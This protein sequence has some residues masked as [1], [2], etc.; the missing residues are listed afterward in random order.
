M[1]YIEPNTEVK[2]LTDVPL[3]PDY[4][5]T[6]YFDN[7][8][9]QTNYF[10][11]RV[12][13]SFND[14]S[15][16]R[17]TRGWL[18]VGW[19]ADAFGG[20]VIKDMYAS[21]YMMFKNSNFENKW[22]YAFVDKVEYVNNNTVDVQYHIDVMQTWHFDYILNQCFIE[23]QH[24]TTDNI[25]DNTIPEQLETGEYLDAVLPYTQND[26]TYIG[27]H[28]RYEPGILLAIAF[29]NDG[30]YYPGKVVGGW[31]SRGDYFTG[32]NTIIYGTNS[33]DVALLNTSL[34]SITN[35]AKSD[36]V[37][38]LCMCPKS[39]LNT[40]GTPKD[41]A[42]IS[43]NMGN[44]V[45]P[46]DGYVPRNK[47]LL[48]YPYQMLYVTNNI[49]NCAEYHLEFFNN[50]TSPSFD[51]WANFST[52]PGMICEPRN[53]KGVSFADDEKITVDGFPMCAWTFDA[54]RAWL[55]QNAGT[56]I[57]NGASLAL[58][59]VSTIANPVRAAADF[60]GGS[61][62][63]ANT[64]GILGQTLNAIGQVF[65]HSRVPPQANG[66]SNGS[67]V[68]QSS[69][70]TFSFYKKYIKP[71]FARIIDEY[72]DMYG[73]ATHRVGVPNRAVRRCYTYVKTI[74]CSIH[75]NIPSE[76]I[77]EIQNLFNKGIRFW[78]STAVFGNYDPSVNNNTV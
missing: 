12:R 57:A 46:L 78:R 41:P 26:S 39:L 10:L 22:F 62:S 63:Y 32:V 21:T 1:A 16:Q 43:F 6:L 40:D 28:F 25:G 64:G 69:L 11:S 75:G 67:L 42:H 2:F 56:I 31:G 23:R 54:F 48:T 55:A 45:G 73:Y 5:N 37:L 8:A 74:G 34:E 30:T 29:A 44:A 20:N 71:E 3:D 27:P 51:I 18:R 14:L 35:A 66:S 15:Y 4:E 38:G 24:S 61:L 72:F 17:K 77:I 36:G 13:R 58:G 65:D 53:Y 59:W 9:Q 47:K 60:A 52:N 7:I 50:P 76:D 70:L 19:V 49:G 68:Y 33:G